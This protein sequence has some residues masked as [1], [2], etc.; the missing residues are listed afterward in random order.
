LKVGLDRFNRMMV[1]T[2]SF[3]YSRQNET[4]KLEDLTS[5]ELESVLNSR[6]MKLL[7][8]KQ[9][10][11]SEL[12]Y[13]KLAFF[14][15]SKSS[16]E[17][18]R[19]I[20]KIFRKKQL[21]VQFSNCIF[22][23]IKIWD[24]T[25]WQSLGILKIQSKKMQS[26]IW[27]ILAVENISKS[28]SKFT[29]GIDG[30]AF[31][32]VPT[33]KI[34]SIEK[35][36]KTSFIRNKLV[37]L[38]R[39]INI[40]KGK[41]DQAIQR[42]GIQ[43]L[44]YFEF[45]KGFLKTKV[46]NEKFTDFKMQYKQII[47]KPIQYFNDQGIK[48]EKYN[49]KLKMNL[50]NEL[51]PLRLKRYKSEDILWVFLFETNIKSRSLG[52]LTIKDRT[53]QMLLKLIME[54]Y[55]EPL[56][57]TTSFGF[58]PG[59]NAHQLIS[60]ISNNLAW[61]R[62]NMTKIKRNKKI[63]NWDFKV[64]T[65]KKLYNRNYIQSWMP[66][67]IL[68]ADIESCFDNILHSWL[69]NNIPMPFGYEWL[70]P[71][72]LKYNICV[73]K[74]SLDK[75]IKN[76]KF[77][78]TFIKGYNNKYYFL[79]YAK[80]RIKGIAQSGVLSPLLMNW[81]LDGLYDNIK[82]NSI[83]SKFIFSKDKFKKTFLGSF[84]LAEYIKFYSKSI[85]DK[86]VRNK[87]LKVYKK[88]QVFIRSW[89][90]RFADD[91]IV[92]T[93]DE[94][95][96]CNIK[97]GIEK[98]LSIR[99]L[100][101]SEKNSIIKKWV[102]NQKLH[103]LNWTFHAVHSKIKKKHKVCWI[104]KADTKIA[105]SIKDWIGLYI[106]P[107]KKSIL[108][109]RKFIKQILTLKNSNNE[110]KKIIKKLAYVITGWS[111]YFSPAPKQIYLRS[112]LDWYIWSKCKSYL[113]KK[114]GTRGFDKAFRFYLRDSNGQF[115]SLHIDNK[116]NLFIVPKLSNLSAESNWGFLRLN[117]ELFHNSFL[118]RPNAFFKRFIKNKIYYKDLK[119]SLCVSQ[120]F[121]C[122]ICNERIFNF[123]NIASENF[124]F[125]HFIKENA[126]IKNFVVCDKNSQFFVKLFNW[127]A[128]MESEDIYYFTGNKLTKNLD[129]NYCLPKELSLYSV[130]GFYTFFYKL[131]NSRENLFLVHKQ[132]HKEKIIYDRI[133]RKLFRAFFK[134]ELNKYS[135]TK[136]TVS[137]TLFQ[138]CC[139]KA[140]I[141]LFDYLLLENKYKFIFNSN[142]F[143]RAINIVSES[144]FN[145]DLADLK[146]FDKFT[147][148]KK[149]TINKNYLKIYKHRMIKKK[150]LLDYRSR[151]I[152]YGLKK[153]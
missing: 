126:F 59:R 82:K 47:E 148:R 104:F 44:S 26:L 2:R 17:I 151:R 23:R 106:Y 107:A 136:K 118:N 48:N 28:N 117:K 29:P 113:Y 131:L 27:K 137:K 1:I 91:F 85:I 112:H 125:T 4:W 41:S 87:L 58:R 60:L 32:E 138:Q 73:E 101:F 35:I 76:G 140:I 95:V 78:N 152:N 92:V 139:F 46:N 11:M 79:E 69:I 128:S 123:N 102:I 9:W 20:D 50:L 88:F 56:G 18:T 65:I 71:R 97:F 99:G 67:H 52:I 108:N 40:L 21:S 120:D 53:L 94:D 12:K 54:P 30:I 103:F 10:P 70:L 49:I 153:Q 3:S 43:N 62:F 119:S 64:N 141:V 45:K 75:L 5:I 7:K 72:I 109:L 122:F 114:F 36:L 124:N 16:S 24:L 61:E 146:I 121:K 129:I 89:I 127:C 93:T 37:F 14:Y 115:T 105:G 149:K 84:K 81:T 80:H 34:N 111:N 15:H 98:F 86:L 96:M 8:Q 51:K 144:L 6:G 133:L 63:K 135:L 90:Y 77:D 147:I 13:K 150:K 134:A 22:D 42:K 83:I 66:R 74:L 19:K 143:K 116:T 33:T 25:Y 38:K 55:M 132:C 57:D 100:K 142:I 110:L 145:N 39:N 31:K 130:L 68:K